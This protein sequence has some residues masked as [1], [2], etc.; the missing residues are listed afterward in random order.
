MGYNKNPRVLFN[1]NYCNALTSERPSHYAR[2]NRHFCS[3][4]CYSLYRKDFLPKNEQHA[5]KNGGIP[6]HEKL[7]RIKAR[8]DLNHAIID[9]KLKRLP[10]EVCGNGKSEAHHEDYTKPL[11]V[12]WLC[13]VCHHHIHKNKVYENSELLSDGGETAE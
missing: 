5:Y 2:K 11:S 12:K 7:I 8:S 3:M 4:G 13:D 1:C 10:C 6:L 9:K